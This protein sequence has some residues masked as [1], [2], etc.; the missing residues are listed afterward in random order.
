MLIGMTVFAYKNSP[1]RCKWHGSPQACSKLC[2]DGCEKS[3]ISVYIHDEIHIFECQ[4]ESVR[5]HLSVRFHLSIKVNCRI[6]QS[7]CEGRVPQNPRSMEFAS[8]VCKLDLLVW[9]MD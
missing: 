2:G 3:E 4:S 1:F 5:L 7:M 8:Q 9:I 6:L